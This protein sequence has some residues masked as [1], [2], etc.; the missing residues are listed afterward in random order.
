MNDNHNK[1]CSHI[2]LLH[3]NIVNNIMKTPPHLKCNIHPDEKNYVLCL[4][5]SQILCHNNAEQICI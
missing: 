5:C 1:L 4:H 3:K 2:Q